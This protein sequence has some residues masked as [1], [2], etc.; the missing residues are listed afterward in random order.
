MEIW[1][2]HFEKLGRKDRGGRWRDVEDWVD[3]EGNDLEGKV[4]KK[5]Y[6]SGFQDGATPKV[7][8][9]YFSSSLVSINI[10]QAVS[11]VRSSSLA[12]G[13]RSYSTQEGSV[14]L[15]NVSKVFPEC[16]HQS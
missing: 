15:R 10:A 13:S 8:S 2:S 1:R 3:D 14:I 5:T 16:E 4:E 11:A 9:V 6:V 7:A 12:D